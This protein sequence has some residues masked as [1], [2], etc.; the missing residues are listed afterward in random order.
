M[1]FANAVSIALSMAMSYTP[2]LQIDGTGDLWRGG[3]VSVFA[4]KLEEVRDSGTEVRITAPECASACTLFLVADDVCT[5]PGTRFAFHSASMNGDIRHPEALRVNEVMALLYGQVSP[6]LEE[7]WRSGPSES[8][9]FRY[10]L[11]S[12]FIDNTHVRECD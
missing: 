9:R 8:G 3:H 5:T 4:E 6:S 2:P 1:S 11:G 7:W 12:W 10:I